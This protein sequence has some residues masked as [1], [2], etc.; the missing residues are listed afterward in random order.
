MA[1]WQKSFP[2]L[3]NEKG[4]T[5]F[6]AW[7]EWVLA[8]GFAFLFLFLSTDRTIYLFDEGISLTAGLRVSAGQV[9][10]RDFHFIYG[11]A[12]PYALAALFKVFGP[13]VFVA[14]MFDLAIKSLLVATSFVAL[15]KICR[16][17]IAIVFSLAL[18]LWVFILQI[19]V[20]AVTPASLFGVWALL[21]LQPVFIRHVSY[22]RLAGTGSL[23]G[24]TTLFRHDCGFALLATVFVVFFAVPFL[25]PA[26]SPIGWKQLSFSFLV[27]LAGFVLVVLPPLIAYLAVA[28]W[29]DI[30]FQLVEYFVKYYRVSRGLPMSRDLGRLGEFYFLLPGFTALLAGLA[31]LALWRTRSRAERATRIPVE[32]GHIGFLLSFG[33][34]AG[35]MW[36]KG[37]VRIEFSQNYLALV[38]TLFVLGCLVHLAIRY[39]YWLKVPV[40]LLGGLCLLCTIRFTLFRTHSSLEQKSLVLPYLLRP[41]TQAPFPPDRNWCRLR[42]PATSDMCYLV[43]PDHMHAVEFLEGRICPGE[44]LYVG[45]RHHDRIFI[46]D[47][48]TYFMLDRLPAT[49]WSHMDP[50]L[51]NTVPIQQEMISELQANKPPYI[52]LDSEYESF[53]EPNDSSV[54]SGVVLLDNFIMQQ[55]QP[56]KQFGPLTILTRRALIS[57]GSTGSTSPQTGRGCTVSN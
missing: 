44:T 42:N 45:L 14:R 50:H 24:L 29:H 31:C 36:T 37:L 17:S 26:S 23:I 11:P 5:A 28:P 6:A 16:L 18:L 8:F 57:D 21:F 10:Y 30:W 19:H 52:I 33:F 3:S 40:Y 49:K 56:V 15:R 55:Y 25:R 47:N 39:P 20:V 22:R 51:Q 34:L 53:H 7:R 9:P 1:E 46:N 2:A 27:L 12:L 13:T 32:S 4:P 38:P 48:G 54:S 43:S 35:L 41:Q